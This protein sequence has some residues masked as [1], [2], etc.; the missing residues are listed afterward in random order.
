MVYDS[1]D[2]LIY[3]VSDKPPA[4]SQDEKEFVLALARRALD[5][6]VREG[7]RLKIDSIPDSLLGLR[8]KKPVDVT[9]WNLGEL[10]GSQIATNDNIVESVI[11]ATIRAARDSRF[12]TVSKNE[13]NDIRIEIFIFGDKI[14][15]NSIESLLKKQNDF[16]EIGI[17]IN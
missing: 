4:L 11:E 2:V 17:S 6:F 9:L 5:L 15:V 7:K 12:K 13:L 8:K 1:P 14:S 16:G 3:K 10:R